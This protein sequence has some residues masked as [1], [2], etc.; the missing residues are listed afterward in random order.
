[1]KLQPSP[2]DRTVFI[3]SW[4]PLLP[5]NHNGCMLTVI[6]VANIVY[7]VLK[8]SEA[9]FLAVRDMEGGWS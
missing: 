1:M 6:L 2:R 8:I 9:K 5:W 7:D 4:K 3:S